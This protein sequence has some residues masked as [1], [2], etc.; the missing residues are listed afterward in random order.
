M[1]RL[2]T[3]LLTMLLTTTSCSLLKESNK[4]VTKPKMLGDICTVKANGTDKPSI[5][6]TVMGREFSDNEFNLYVSDKKEVEEIYTQKR[7]YKSGIINANKYKCVPHDLW[8]SIRYFLN[9]QP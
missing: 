2:T 6:C 7:V 8:Y 3:T 4:P 1:L 9:R 5:F